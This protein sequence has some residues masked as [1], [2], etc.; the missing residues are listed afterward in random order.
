MFPFPYFGK[1]TIT[2]A[3]APSAK[4]PPNYTMLSTTKAKQFETLRGRVHG[5]YLTLYNNFTA[6]DK[7]RF[8]DIL[9]RNKRNKTLSFVVI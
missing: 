4:S 5:Q 7:E 9:E 1:T 3:T 6:S 8:N 2:F